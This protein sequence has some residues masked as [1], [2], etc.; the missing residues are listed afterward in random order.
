MPLL[1]RVRSFLR[2]FVKR[3]S[4][5]SDLDDEI[6]F[7][8]DMLAQE[9]IRQGA[10]PKEAYRSARLRFGGTEQVKERVREAR[11]GAWFDTL[12]QDVRF[13]LRMLRKNPGFATVA[14]LTLALG[15]GATTTIFSV[16]SEERR[17]GKEW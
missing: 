7:H 9:Q 1:S 3:T 10:A 17:V 15:I 13:A 11:V 12:V 4:Q 6:R 5:E 8:V 14:I 2:R 16:R